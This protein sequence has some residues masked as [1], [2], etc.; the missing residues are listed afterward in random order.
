ME[1]KNMTVNE[2]IKLLSRIE[3]KNLEV[4]FPGWCGR[5]ENG[6]LIEVNVINEHTDCVTVNW[7]KKK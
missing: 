4:M 1:D 2:M 6:D 7:R 5:E 3:D